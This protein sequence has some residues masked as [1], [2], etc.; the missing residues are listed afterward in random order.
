MSTKE[1]LAAHLLNLYWTG[2]GDAGVEEA[3]MNFADVIGNS[4]DVSDALE[5][6]RGT[7][8]RRGNGYAVTL[9]DHFLM[10]ADKILKDILCLK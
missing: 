5:N 10:L 6:G 7:I 4:P 2:A 8:L 3:I 9:T 1:R